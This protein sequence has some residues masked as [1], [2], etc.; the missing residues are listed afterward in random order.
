M[1]NGYAPSLVF[2]LCPVCGDRINL[3]FVTTSGPVPYIHRARTGRLCRLVVVP[4]PTPRQEHTVREV[5]RD[6]FIETILEEVL[7]RWMA[8][9]PA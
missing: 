3:P 1:R 7:Q 2:L 8:E 9:Q 6:A 5:P 4:D